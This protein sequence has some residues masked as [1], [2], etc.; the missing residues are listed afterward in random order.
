MSGYVGAAGVEPG[1]ELVEPSTTRPK[2]GSPLSPGRP[3]GRGATIGK[4]GRGAAWLARQSG[5]LEV[6]SSNLGAPTI[7]KPRS[8]G[9]FFSP[10]STADGPVD[11]VFPVSSPAEAPT[12]PGAIANIANA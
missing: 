2:N 5:G 11:A 3:G 12:T 8:G 7:G 10:V 1:D 6:P 4:T 9:A